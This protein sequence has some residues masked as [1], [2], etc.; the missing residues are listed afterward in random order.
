M[1]DRSSDLIHPA[2]GAVEIGDLF[3]IRAPAGHIYPQKD[4]AVPRFFMPRRLVLDH[5]QIVSVPAEG[6]HAF[7]GEGTVGIGQ[8]P[9]GIF[10]QL[11][12]KGLLGGLFIGEKFGEVGLKE[13]VAV[14][15]KAAAGF[16]IHPVFQ[17]E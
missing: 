14:L 15:G 16:C 11:G 13:L 1:S 17:D 9:M 4:F 3:H 5:E 10:A 2:P 12:G 8:H 7:L 6:T